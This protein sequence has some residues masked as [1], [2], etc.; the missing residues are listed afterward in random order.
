MNHSAW[1]GC[2]SYFDE[3]KFLFSSTINC[4]KELWP[5]YHVNQLQINLSS[6]VVT[7]THH[8]K[9]V[10][11]VKRKHRQCERQLSKML[12]MW[13]KGKS[14]LLKRKHKTLY[15]SIIIVLLSL[16]APRRK[17]HQEIIDSEFELKPSKWNRTFW[18]LLISNKSNPN[19]HLLHQH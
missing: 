14:C 13:T 16:S 5:S 18:A 11:V 6:E 1:K 10:T 3:F 9:N 7:L 2:S 17:S 8:H 15:F 12:T 4:L 19:Y